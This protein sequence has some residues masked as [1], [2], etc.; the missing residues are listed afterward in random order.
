MVPTMTLLREVS[1]AVRLPLI[2][3]GGIMDG[4]GIREAL[5]AGAAAVQMGTA[6]IPCPESGAAAVY[7]RAVLEAA[8][9]TT[10]VT[11]AFSGRPARGLRNR[12]MD[13]IDPHAADILPYPWQNVATRALRAAA[14]RAGR[15][16]FLSLWAGQNARLAREMPA[17]E[18]VAVLAREA[19]LE[20]AKEP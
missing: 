14:G 5:A 1:R 4:E 19:G 13:E 16:E 7:K 3:S 8:A 2:A 9:D 12:F 15:P 10:A 20:G 17:A 6:F 11:R 18:L